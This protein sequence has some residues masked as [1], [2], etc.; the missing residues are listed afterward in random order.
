M[1]NER[2]YCY[3]LFIKDSVLSCFIQST[4]MASSQISKADPYQES[5]RE[6][7]QRTIDFF[8]DN[9]AL[10]PDPS[11]ETYWQVY[12][13]SKATFGHWSLMFESEDTGK[14]FT[15]ELLKTQQRDTDNFEVIMR[16]VVMDIKN[17]PQLK[18]SPL[19]R[20]RATGYKIF[21]QAYIVL[22]DMGGYRAF[23]NNCQTYCKLL[24]QELKAPVDAETVTDKVIKGVTTLVE[25]GAITEAIVIL[26]HI[27]TRM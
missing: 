13:L 27:F 11:T 4:K 26:F 2:C 14:A 8:V 15:I 7:K 1:I 3:Q 25:V 10:Y 17:Y 21:G 5:E 20:I 22:R 18:Q 19:G 24:A 23:D 12:I 16:F 9:R 6:Y